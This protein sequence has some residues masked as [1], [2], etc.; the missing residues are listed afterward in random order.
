MKYCCYI[1]FSK[2]INQYYIGST[3]DIE[4]RLR[5]HNKGHFGG[6]S[7]TYKATDW[8]LFL[9]ITCKSIEQAVSIESGIKKM[10][11][12]KYIE[13]LKRYPEM[14]EKILNDSNNCN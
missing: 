1:L 7:Y 9:L 3:S 12:R 6:K 2:T 4:E 11:S 8:E 10:K 14:I 5:L 13:N